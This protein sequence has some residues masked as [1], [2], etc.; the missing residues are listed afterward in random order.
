MA[1]KINFVLTLMAVFLVFEYVSGCGVDIPQ[2][3]EFKHDVKVSGEVKVS[4]E[5]E[6]EKL[7]RE[8]QELTQDLKECRE[9][10]FGYWLDNWTD[11]G[12]WIQGEE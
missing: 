9:Q 12:C 7:K 1:D 6:N 5:F 3:Y 4:L 10:L 8:N 2:K 11:P